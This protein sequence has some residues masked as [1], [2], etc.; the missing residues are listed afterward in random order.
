MFSGP[1][2]EYGNWILLAVMWPGKAIPFF[3]PYFVYETTGGGEWRGIAHILS[4]FEERDKSLR[5]EHVRTENKQE[6]FLGAARIVFF[7]S[8]RETNRAEVKRRRRHSDDLLDNIFPSDG[9]GGSFM[10]SMKAN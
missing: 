3:G 5:A 2:G 10:C 8:Q 7:A 4:I 9:G 1:L 6:A